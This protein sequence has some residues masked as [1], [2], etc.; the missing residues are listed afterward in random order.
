MT[1]MLEQCSPAFCSLLLMYCQ[2]ELSGL[3]A[4][5]HVCSCTIERAV[6]G[7]FR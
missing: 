7:G 5:P 1:F 2:T 6:R 3:A 4:S